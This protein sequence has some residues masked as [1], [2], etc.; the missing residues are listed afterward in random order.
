MELTVGQG[1]IQYKLNKNAQ[2]HRAMYCSVVWREGNGWESHVLRRKTE[3]GRGC[4]VRSALE[5]KCS[6]KSERLALGRD[7]GARQ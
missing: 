1:P 4:G 6:G 5:T 7:H 2:A 3:Q